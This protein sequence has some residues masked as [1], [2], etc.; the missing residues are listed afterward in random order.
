VAERLAAATQ[1][2]ESVRLKDALREVMQLAR[3]G[4]Q[5]FND[6]KPWDLV[7]QGKKQE[8]ADAILWHL[9]L[10]KTLSVALQPFLP[11][12]SAEIWRQLGEPGPSP[13]AI[14]E[15]GDGKDHWPTGALVVAPGQKFGEVKPLVKK[16]DIKAVLAEFEAA[17]PQ[18][19][20][21]MEQHPPA[22]AAAA[23][24]TSAKP[25]VTIDDFVKLDLRVAHVISCEP[26]PKA[27]KIWVL[28]VDIG[29]EKRQILAGLREHV[30]PE[31]LVGKKIVV[32]A[33][34]A[35]RAIRGLE[36]QGMVLA[37]E[38]DGIVAPLVPAKD[39]P[40][41]AGVK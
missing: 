41:G 37:A 21:K 5:R 28:Q 10:I 30:K 17:S 34:L 36:S 25:T 23:A 39:I 20:E 14:A 27:D 32:I 12:L 7:K 2:I 19:P 8:A 6:L 9:G 29:T 13:R 24:P 35:P 26:H 33:N 4:N 11:T 1:H 22:A 31:E 3:L 38:A 40:A 18:E 16:L 15:K